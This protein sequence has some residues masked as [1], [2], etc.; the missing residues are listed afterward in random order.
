L[1]D[2]PILGDYDLESVVELQSDQKSQYLPED[3]L[4]DLRERGST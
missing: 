3:G 4:E 1:H 2:S